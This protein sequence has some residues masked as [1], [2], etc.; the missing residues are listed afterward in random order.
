MQLEFDFSFNKIIEMTEY[1]L[2]RITRSDPLL[3]YPQYDKV[4]SFMKNKGLTAIMM[5]GKNGKAYKWFFNTNS[6][7]GVSK[8]L[9][10]RLHHIDA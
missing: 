2:I 10:S 1:E 3:D 6:R 4:Y 7:T 9:V 8:Y 5:T